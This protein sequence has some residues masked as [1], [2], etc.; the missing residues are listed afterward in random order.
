[1]F[2][3]QFAATEPCH[4]KYKVHWAC[5][6]IHCQLFL[7][8]SSFVMQCIQS[9]KKL[10]YVKFVQLENASYN[11]YL[12]EKC[13]LNCAYR[14][15]SDYSKLYKHLYSLYAIYSLVQRAIYYTYK[16]KLNQITVKLP[17]VYIMGLQSVSNRFGSTLFHLV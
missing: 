1:M 2:N 7:H 16:E 12:N 5:E 8:K 17:H 9:T 15:I 6:I 11:S 10:A 3:V 4:P 13:K 14:Y